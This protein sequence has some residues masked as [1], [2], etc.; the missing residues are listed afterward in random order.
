MD[1]A[2]I[3][4]S[5]GLAGVAYLIFRGGRFI[6]KAESHFGDIEKLRSET[7]G[8]IEKLRSDIKGDMEKLR[9]DMKG[10]T[11]K[12][13]SEMNKNFEESRKEIMEIKTDISHIKERLIFIEALLFFS[14]MGPDPASS[15]S[16]SM[17]EVWKKRKMKQVE[18]KSK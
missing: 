15:R 9:L 8:D 3:I 4:G 6:Q 14:G 1:W 17:R 13:R 18:A 7:S 2:L 16:E 5:S 10:D 11:E 12:L